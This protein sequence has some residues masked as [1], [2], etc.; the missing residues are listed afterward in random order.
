MK[1]YDLKPIND[2]AKSFY[3]KAVVWEEEDVKTLWSYGVLV[4]E[5]KNGVPF[6][7]YGISKTTDRHIREFLKQNGF[8]VNNKK[9]FKHTVSD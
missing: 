3:S 9:T 4:A 7:D 6:V 1:C 8:K 2:S 5:I